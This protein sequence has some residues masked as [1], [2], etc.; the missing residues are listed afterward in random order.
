[1]SITHEQAQKLIQLNMDQML[2]WEESAKLS[3]H[4]RGCGKCMLYASEI[5]EVADMLTPLLKRQ[6]N[7]QPV[8]LS[9]GALV[10]KNENSQPKPLLAIRTAAVSLAIMALFFSG[11]LYCSIPG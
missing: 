11:M 9:I 3:A 6:W 4:L 8:P 10:E 1:M 2:S 7:I 5:K